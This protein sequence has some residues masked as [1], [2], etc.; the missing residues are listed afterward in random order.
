MAA[1]DHEEVSRPVSGLFCYTAD[2]FSVDQSDCQQQYNRQDRGDD[3][4][5]GKEMWKWRDS[6]EQ[7]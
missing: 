7:N 6:T 2:K 3:E 1:E 5:L 4:G